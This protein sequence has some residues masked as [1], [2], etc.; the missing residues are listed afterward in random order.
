MTKAS[1]KDY[2]ENV[3]IRVFIFEDHWMCREALVAVLGQQEGIDLVGAAEQLTDGLRKAE[4]IRP[5]VVLMDI[6]F[7]GEDLGI[8]ATAILKEKMPETKVIIFTDFPDE[9][10]LRGAIKAGASGFLLKRE[11]KDPET[12]IKAI[13]AVYNNDAFMTPS[14][15]AKLLKEVRRLSTGH[16]YQLTDRELEILKLIKKGKENREISIILNIKPRTVA[17]HVSNILY[18]MNAKNRTEA[19]AIATREGIVD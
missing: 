14:I 7:S 10:K 9:E 8:Q 15:I 5:D 18:K 2:T 17:N 11:V 12:I 6:R 19:V 3:R 1:N 16:K 4:K 13:R